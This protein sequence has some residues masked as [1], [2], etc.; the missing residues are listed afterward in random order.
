MAYLSGNYFALTDKGLVRKT[1][2]DY[3]ITSINPFGNVLLMVADGMGGANKGEYASSKL[4]KYIASQFLEI[5]KELISVKQI[6]NWLNKVIAKA[7]ELIYNKAQKDEEFKG[8][9]TTLS[10]CYLVKDLLVIAQVGDS[11]IYMADDSGMKQISVDQTY[12]Q[13]LSHNHK[14]KDSEMSSHKDRHKI[15]NAIGT[16]KIAN[17]DIQ[18]FKYSGEKLLLC[19]DGLYNNV[20]KSIIESILMGNDSTDK[21]CHQLITFGNASGGTDNMAIVIWESNK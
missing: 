2:E 10:L 4:L 12:V 18:S 1:N 3:A 8:M 5:E 9:G 16:K 20:S 7:N 11:R 6:S 14:I 21:K 13:Y 19:S 17:I 15:T